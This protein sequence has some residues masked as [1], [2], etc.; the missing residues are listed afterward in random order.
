MPGINDKEHAELVMLYGIAVEDIERAK[1]QQWVHIYAVLLAQGSLV[2]LYKN[3]YQTSEGLFFIAVAI[4]TALG[5]ALIGLTQWDLSRSRS[6]I[7]AYARRLTAKSQELR[8][9][10]KDRS[11]G[12]VMYPVI[13]G[14][15]QIAAGF[16]FLWLICA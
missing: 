9:A 15:F 2:A 5:L 6:L 12:R 11:V 4:L 13:L 14:I 7:E 1:R 16:F 8:N 10:N 3:A